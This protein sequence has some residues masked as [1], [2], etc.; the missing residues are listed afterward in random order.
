MR[1]NAAN[2]PND[3]TY[4]V[5]DPKGNFV[6]GRMEP[7]ILFGKKW[8]SEPL[9]SKKIEKV[10]CCRRRD[11]LPSGRTSGL[12]V[13]RVSPVNDLVAYNSGRHL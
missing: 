2:D 4:V 6:S 11:W 13:Y 12:N 3:R 1:W 8:R 10:V 7:D 9:F 5:T